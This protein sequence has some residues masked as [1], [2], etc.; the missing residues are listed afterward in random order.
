MRFHLPGGEVDA[1]ECCA[2]LKAADT[3]TYIA[4]N[5]T[6][7]YVC[8]SF[9]GERLRIHAEQRKPAALLFLF[10]VALMHFGSMLLRRTLR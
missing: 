4:G 3:T 2:T 1:A 5:S 9:C 10:V 7:R 6:R 8:N